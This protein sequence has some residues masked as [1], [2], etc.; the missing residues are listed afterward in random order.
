M[1]K[2]R[3]KSGIP[4]KYVAHMIG[5]LDEDLKK[6]IN[7][8]KPKTT[9]DYIGRLCV[10]E[11]YVNSCTNKP[12]YK[13]AVENMLRAE[14]DQ[15]HK[16]EKSSENDNLRMQRSLMLK[17]YKKYISD[18]EKLHSK[19]LPKVD[20]INSETGFTAAYVLF[21]KVIS[22]LYL[23]CDCIKL[24]FWFSGS[25]LREIDETMDIAQYFIIE[26]NTQTGQNHIRNWFR[27]NKSPK[28][29]ICRDSISKWDA[30]I[31]P[32]HSE[33]YYKNLKNEIYNKKSKYIHP[34]LNSIRELFILD[35]FNGQM[36]LIGFDYEN[37]K[38]ERKLYELAHFFRSSIWSSYQVF[39]FCFKDRMPLEK[40]DAE[41]ILKYN[42]LF[43]K[44]DSIEW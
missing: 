37:C 6:W 39:L 10:P 22:L 38:Y 35:E 5:V 8:D 15:R 42:K 12:N 1:K 36:K 41:L 25:H 44:L 24:G 19:Y 13:S 11:D 16:D 3:K 23:V 17:S 9:K 2:Y 30:S 14:R 40:T 43:E 21:F 18:L 27:A 32:E 31:N 20:I 33:E 26:E 29:Q 34:T 4:I 7:E 28:H